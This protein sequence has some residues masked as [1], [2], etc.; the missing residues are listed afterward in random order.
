MPDIIVP[1][2]V[3]DREAA[4][5]LVERLGSDVD[6]YKVGHQLFTAEGPDI[7]R[8]LRDA[9]KRVFLDLKYHDIPNTVARGVESA[10][11]LGAE[12]TTI[13]VSGGL[14]MMRAAAESAGEG[15]RV[16]GVTVMTSMTVTDVEG[17]WDREIS[18]L[19]EETVR[20]SQLAAEA[21]LGGV[22]SSP[23]EVRVIK[24]AVDGDFRVVTPGIRFEGGDTHDQARVAA[25]GVAAA[26]G[27][28]YLVIG[29][30]ITA[31]EDPPAA[32]RRARDE[33]E[34]ALRNS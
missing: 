2:D 25:P 7:V 23:Q 18:A 29:R 16:V 9:G 6:F 1:L 31:A 20:L 33:I 4:L 12:L 17:V 32:F 5:A 15:L 26:E 14:E 22:V 27:S 34:E 13:H 8:A 21:G 11:A 30:A 28:D 24:R 3:P 19:R 10:R